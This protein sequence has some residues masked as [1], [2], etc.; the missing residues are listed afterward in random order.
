MYSTVLTDLSDTKA[1]EK[2]CGSRGR[3]QGRGGG[4]VGEG[5]LEGGDHVLEGQGHD[6]DGQGHGYELAHFVAKNVMA[7]G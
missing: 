4:P 7:L 5:Q 1:K 3:Q 2:T 6:Q